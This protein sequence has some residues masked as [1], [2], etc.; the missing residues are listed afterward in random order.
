MRFTS[1]LDSD[2][3]NC[4]NLEMEHEQISS[5]MTNEEIANLVRLSVQ[6]ALEAERQ[7]NTKNTRAVP[8]PPSPPPSAHRSKPKLP[9]TKS[10]NHSKPSLFP[11]FRHALTAKFAIDGDCIGGDYERVWYGITRLED[12]A[13]ARMHPWV[14]QNQH[15]A[16][17]T[18]S[19]FMKTME[20]MFGDTNRQK[21][22]L[23]RLNELRQKSRSFGDMLAEFDQLVMEAGGHQWTNDVK[24]SFLKRAMNRE[25]KDK[26]I[27]LDGKDDFDEYR[28]QVKRVANE[29]DDL[30]SQYGN[31]RRPTFPPNPSSRPAVDPNAMD[32][33]PTPVANANA[34]TNKRRAK[35]VEKSEMERR[36]QNRLCFRCG[37]SEHSI[38]GCMFAPARQPSAPT[39]PALINEPRPISEPMLESLED[40]S[41]S[42]NE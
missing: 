42:E 35:W 37:S 22:A 12:A 21:R 31:W 1:N 8:Q 7:Q 2:E 6:Q 13:A 39:K 28:E 40:N 10:Y 33:Q 4:S 15:T 36:R 3:S 24:K 20:T 30:K 32:W 29:M 25:L 27:T 5:G 19:E 26:L 18:V 41:D 38:K 9:E 34:A 16:N 17:F 11:S 23:D 14:D